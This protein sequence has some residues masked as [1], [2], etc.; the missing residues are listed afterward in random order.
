M[1]MGKGGMT[2][3]ATVLTIEI[4]E[5]LGEYRRNKKAAEENM[6]LAYKALGK[7]MEGYEEIIS[8]S[9]DTKQHL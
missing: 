7:A 9:E 5:N 8:S 2:P 1:E 6:R 3:R 4:L